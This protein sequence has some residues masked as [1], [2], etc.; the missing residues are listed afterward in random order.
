MR[1]GTRQRHCVYRLAVIALLMLMAGCRTTSPAE[2]SLADLDFHWLHQRRTAE[3]LFEEQAYAEAET[4]LLEAADVAPTAL[5][6]HELRAMAATAQAHIGEDKQ[7]MVTAR[8]ID[9]EAFADY[10]VLS[11]LSVQNLSREIIDL[12]GDTAILEWPE[13]IHAEAF[14]MRAAAYERED[15]PA[16]AAADY[17]RCADAAGEATELMLPALIDAAYQHRKLEQHDSA[18]AT[19]RR[20]IETIGDPPQRVH[21]GH[22]AYPLA[23]GGLADLLADE[24][25]FAESIAVLYRYPP[26]WSTSRSFGLLTRRGDIYLAWGKPDEALMAYREALAFAHKH[27][28]HQ[29]AERTIQRLNE[30]VIALEKATE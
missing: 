28:S 22:N 13:Q 18:K 1:Y 17:T 25:R 4:A 5:A 14:R 26:E 23:I 7:A 10:A 8:S 15:M 24:E 19:Y 16:A 3:R 11:V 2:K 12:Y 29:H 21:G 6:R 30:K 20:V 9:D 27:A